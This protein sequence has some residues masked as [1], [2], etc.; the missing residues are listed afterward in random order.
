[1]KKTLY[2]ILEV[3][4]TASDEVIKS[5]FEVLSAKYRSLADAGNADAENQ[6]KF[7]AE[8]YRTLANP[9]SRAAYNM[10]LTPTE[11]IPVYGEN[12]GNSVHES[13]IDTAPRTK[14][15]IKEGH[16]TPEIPDAKSWWRNPKLAFAIGISFVLVVGGIFLN[17]LPKRAENNILRA[18]QTNPGAE[19]SGMK[20]RQLPPCAGTNW[21]AWTNCFG[22]MTAS[23]GVH[24]IGE[25]GNGKFNGHG[26][27]LLPNGLKYVGEFR[28]G[29]FNGNGSVTVSDGTKYVGK[30]NDGFLSGHGTTT[31]PD[32]TKYVGEHKQ[33]VLNGQG[34][35]TFPNGGKWV[36][37]FRNA[38]P[39]GR[40]IEYQSD[41][42]I[43][44][45][46][47]WVKGS[48]VGE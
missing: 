4:A 8:A 20:L 48:F 41:G 33:G 27:A 16:Y 25:F 38:M 22:E 44:R 31:L 35:V 47:I 29:N 12:E 45:T 37:E 21:K 11:T 42:T 1:M 26:T 6:L 30:F 43:L 19:G 23:N 32:G 5:S 40:G 39:D 2:D 10:K 46:G 17:N 7:L 34:S 14:R 24:Y 36:G 15:R 13:C 18:K 28:D 9:R 3:T